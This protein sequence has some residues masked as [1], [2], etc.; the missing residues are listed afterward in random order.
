[1]P[2]YH[3][4]SSLEVAFIRHRIGIRTISEIATEMGATYTQ[5]QGI[6]HRHGLNKTKEPPT[7]IYPTAK[8]ITELAN[9]GYNR[10][11]ILMAIE[12]V[13]SLNPATPSA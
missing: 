8:M 2:K 7:V 1:M 4:W 12:L 3:R 5:I 11:S 13:R 10:K 6:I 9:K